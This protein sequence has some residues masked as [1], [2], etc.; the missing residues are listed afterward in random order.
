MNRLEARS[1]RQAPRKRRLQCLLTTMHPERMLSRALIQHLT[2]EMHDIDFT[3]RQRDHH[4]VIWVCGYQPGG[5][6]LVRELRDRHPESFV[7]VTGRGSV[8]EW[9]EP[10]LAAGADLVCPWPLPYAELN[11]ILHRTRSVP[12]VG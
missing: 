7:I 11:R 4:D 2:A 12:R 3:L 9:R 8:E 1:Q 5:D 6:A 10:V